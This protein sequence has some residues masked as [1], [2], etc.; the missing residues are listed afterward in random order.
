[1]SLFDFSQVPTQSG[2]VAV[3]TG[4]NT[5]LGYQ[6]A[7]ALARLKCRVV[8]AC[9]DKAKAIRAKERLQVEVENPEVTFL[10]LD[11]SSLESVRAFT[12]AYEKQFDRLDLL[13]NNAGVMALPQRQETTDGFEMQLGTNHLGHFLLTGLLLPLLK[14]TPESRVVTLS[15]SAHKFGKIHFDDLQLAKDY[16]SWKAYGQ[17]KVANLLF[18]Q[19]LAR[20][21]EASGINVLS[22]GAHPGFASTDLQRHLPSW[23]HGLTRWVSQEAKNGALPSLYAALGQDIE[24]GDY[25]GPSGF[26]EIKGPAT[27][28]S[29]NDYARDLEVAK[30]LWTISE[31]LVNYRYEF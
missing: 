14:N 29:P 19:E 27:K 5:G 18:A 26:Q 25:C 1:M 30:R 9:R 10:P 21:L 15:S 28:V 2:R 11:L 12:Q 24:N 6:T 4:A 31:D 23:L 22:V 8:L 20:R 7:L 13:V 3:V 17:S 16:G